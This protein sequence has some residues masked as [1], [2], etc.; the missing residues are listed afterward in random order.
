MTRRFFRK[1][2]REGKKENK[3]HRRD[4]VDKDQAEKEDG[5]SDEL[6]GVQNAHGI[7]CDIEEG[8]R[9][10]EKILEKRKAEIHPEGPW[11]PPKEGLD[12][13]QRVMGCFDTCP[14]AAPPTENRNHG[15]KDMTSCFPCVLRSPV[16]GVQQVL[17]KYVSREWVDCRVLSKGLNMIFL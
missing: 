15:G 1:K 9:T 11:M 4:R 17:S 7:K 14:C 12:L 6:P 5:M 8:S 2:I 16:P 13:I 10:N 3:A